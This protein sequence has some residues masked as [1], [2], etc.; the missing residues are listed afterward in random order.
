MGHMHIVL[1]DVER[2][3]FFNGRDRVECVQVQPLMHLPKPWC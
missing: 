1:L 3:E 2:H